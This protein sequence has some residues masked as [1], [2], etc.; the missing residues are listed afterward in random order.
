MFIHQYISS[1]QKR[2]PIL[3]VHM[4]DQNE[5]FCF[6]RGEKELKCSDLRLAHPTP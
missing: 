3:R 6:E 1:F 4:S 5:K 2:K